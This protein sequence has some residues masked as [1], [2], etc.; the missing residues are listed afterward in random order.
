[1]MLRKKL[2]RKSVELDSEVKKNNETINI[3]PEEVKY[4]NLVEKTTAN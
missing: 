3:P 1:M 4:N 2:V